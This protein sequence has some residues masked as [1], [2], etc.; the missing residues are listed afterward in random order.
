VNNYFASLE[1]GATAEGEEMAAS[2]EAEAVPEEAIAE[3][4]TEAEV[5]DGTAAADAATDEI[6]EVP[7][8]AEEDHSATENAVQHEGDATRESQE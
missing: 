8:A 3:G 4:T 7:V 1:Q 5:L 6:A 2:P